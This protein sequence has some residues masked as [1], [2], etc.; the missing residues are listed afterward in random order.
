MAAAAVIRAVADVHKE[1]VAEAEGSML[2]VAEKEDTP[3][4][5]DAGMMTA[6]KEIAASKTAAKETVVTGK[7]TAVTG[8]RTAVRRRGRPEMRTV[9]VAEIMTGMEEIVMLPA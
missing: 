4:A 8:S 7:E 5:E 2:A 3:P 6:V 9:A 1:I